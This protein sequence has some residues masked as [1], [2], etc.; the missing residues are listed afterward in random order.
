MTRKL[1]AAAL[2]ALLAL[3][4]GTQAFAFNAGGTWRSTSGTM[5]YIDPYF[6]VGLQGA[7]GAVYNGQGW[8][9]N[10]MTGLQFQYSVSGMNGWATAT[11]LDNN[12]LRVVSY[13]GTTSYWRR[14]AGRG[15]E[16]QVNPPASWFT[17]AATKANPD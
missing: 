14:I 1:T 3:C 16:E 8:W 10:G 11:F 4:M 9:V 12:N 6:N 17:D 7:N 13:Q 5:V 15:G 2:T